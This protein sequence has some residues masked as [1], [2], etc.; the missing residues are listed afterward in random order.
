MSLYQR[1][2]F[3]IL[4]GMQEKIDILLNVYEPDELIDTV[5]QNP[6]SHPLILN[7]L[8]LLN[9]FRTYEWTIP[10]Q[11]LD[12]NFRYMQQILYPQQ[13]IKQQFP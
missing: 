3:K 11:P 4:N 1:K 8:A 2:P 13:A 5:G 6:T 9:T 7:L 10:Y 12:Y